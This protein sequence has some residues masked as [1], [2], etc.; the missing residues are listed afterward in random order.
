MH[1]FGVANGRKTI[2]NTSSAL[3]GKLTIKQ[4]KI[5][6]ESCFI[7]KLSKHFDFKVTKK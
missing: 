4:I 5:L 3:I 1:R 2:K 7:K 6:F